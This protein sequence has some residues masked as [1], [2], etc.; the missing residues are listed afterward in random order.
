MHFLLCFVCLI[1]IQ[2]P[3]SWSCQ[4]NSCCCHQLLWCQFFRKKKYHLVPI[5]SRA[6]ANSGSFFLSWPGRYRSLCWLGIQDNSCTCCSTLFQK[7]FAF[8]FCHRSLSPAMPFSSP[9]SQKRER[10]RA[11][12]VSGTF[13]S[14]L[15]WI[16]ILDSDKSGLPNPWRMARRTRR[17]C[18]CQYRPV[19]MISLWYVNCIRLQLQSQLLWF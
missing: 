12:M 16:R 6:A 5:R 17:S 7:C 8:S 9:K 14:V 18:K 10:S 13:G 4:S 3:W 19:S 11:W 2:T 15:L 1:P